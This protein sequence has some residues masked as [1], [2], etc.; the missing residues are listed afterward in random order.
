MS[1]LFLIG[2]LLGLCAMALI[3]LSFQYKKPS[4]LC[5][6]Q[7]CACIF[8]VLHYLCLGLNG[9]PNAYAGMTQNIVGLLFRGVLVLA[10]KRRSLLSPLVLS[11][12]CAFSAVVAILTYPGRLISLL[13]TVANFICM[14]GMWTRNANT[15]RIIQLTVISPFWILYNVSALSLAG[16]LTESFNLV[17]IGIYYIRMYHNKKK[18]TP[19]P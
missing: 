2:Q 3:V 17:S 8:F 5:F 16:V 10:E 15:V 18:T 6:F 9:D 1:P 19:A 13:P 7:F 11:G 4:L 12:L 14:G